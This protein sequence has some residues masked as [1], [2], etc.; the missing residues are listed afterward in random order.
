MALATL[1]LSTHIW[2]N[3]IKSM[4]LLLLFPCLWLFMIWAFFFGLSIS[5]GD[6]NSNHIRSGFDGMFSYGYIAFIITSIWFVIA[7]FMHSAMIRSSTGATSVDR[8]TYPKVYNML[9]NMCIS[10]GM[11]MP[12]LQIIDSPSLNAFASG[13]NDNTYAITLTRGIIESLQDDELEAVIAH[14][15]THI[16]NRDVRLLIISVI[17]VGMISFFAEIA[18]RSMVYGNN[19]SS[20]RYGKSDSKNNGLPIVIIA[21]VV[22]AIGYAF[23]ILIRFAISRKREFMADAGA[24]EIT[25]N[26]DAMMKA[27]MRISGRDKV[28]DMPDEVQQMCIENSHN[29]MGLFGTHPPIDDRIK[30][31]AF[32]TGREIPSLPVSL[33]RPPRMPWS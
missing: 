8:K 11:V 9:E 25:K 24:V 17:F 16:I 13:I 30:M 18:F 12:Q 27:L 23:A 5:G 20:R 26:P 22:L 19:Y 28:K 33:R 2:N 3:N 31:I 10:Q 6:P 14:E 15:L 21:L 4:I 32:V 7:W 29:F 1:G